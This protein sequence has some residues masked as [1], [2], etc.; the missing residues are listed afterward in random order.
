MLS[1]HVFKQK[2]VT[3][4]CCDGVSLTVGGSTTANCTLTAK[5]M[6]IL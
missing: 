3:A 4:L 2:H 6:N 1:E 5:V